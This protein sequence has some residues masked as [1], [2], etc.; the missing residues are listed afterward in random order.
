M[1]RPISASGFCAIE[2][3]LKR[4]SDFCRDNKY[5]YC[6]AAMRLVEEIV[7]DLSGAG[8]YNLVII[9]SLVFGGRLYVVILWKA[10]TI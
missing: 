1:V 8:R 10:F 6:S 3:K 2:V 9:W 5:Q 4:E 7:F